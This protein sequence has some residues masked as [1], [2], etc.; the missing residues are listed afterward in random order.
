MARIVV[1]GDRLDL[2][3]SRRDVA[4]VLRYLDETA[5]GE[6]SLEMLKPVLSVRAGHVE[7]EGE[8]EAERVIARFS[9]YLKAKQLRTLDLFMDLD[10]NG[11]GAL[12]EVELV[13]G[14]R[15]LADRAAQEAFWSVSGNRSSSLWLLPRK[16]S[17]SSAPREHRS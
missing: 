16:E 14:L 2:T 13:D 11:D 5:T 4:D 17:V 8:A 6:L 3:F 9:A 15:V 1:P 10:T 12:S 7:E